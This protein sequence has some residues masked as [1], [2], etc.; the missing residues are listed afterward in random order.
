[1]QALFA[2]IDDLYHFALGAIFHVYERAKSEQMPVPLVSVVP[3]SVIEQYVMPTPQHSAPPA[4][5]PRKPLVLKKRPSLSH[6][7]VA[8]NLDTPRVG[9]H[10]VPLTGETETPGTPGV[11]VVKEKKKEETKGEENIVEAAVEEKMT[12]RSLDTLLTE[13]QIEPF[14]LGAHGTH[15]VCIDTTP[16]YVRPTKEFDGVVMKLRYGD[17]VS[18]EGYAGKF[19]RV[20]VEGRVVYMLREDLTDAAAEVFPHFVV[21]E[22]YDVD[23]PSTIRL[24]AVIG[25]EFCGGALELPL[26]AGEYVL[27][28]LMRR[29]I[30][31]LWPLERPRTL[32]RWHVFLRGVLGVHSG[33]IPKTG[34]IMEYTLEHDMG[35]LAYVEAVFP[36]ETILISE[37]NYPENGIYNERTLTREEWRELKPIF[38][39]I[40]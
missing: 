26:T 6:E 5:T 23:A 20:T 18:I 22:A 14:V 33:V 1:M 34:T 4:M 19:A 15:Y 35:H 13:K 12:F 27:Y 31:I 30:R 32:G 3:E 17:S 2:V 28:R 38:I 36:N 37:A 16:A 7:S 9:V 40:T 39:Q 24:R 8:N 10:T 11:I 29:G 21:G 25:D